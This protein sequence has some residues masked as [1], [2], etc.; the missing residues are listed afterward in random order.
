MANPNAATNP[1]QFYEDMSEAELGNL[2]PGPNIGRPSAPDIVEF[3]D[4]MLRYG[5]ERAAQLAEPV[6]PAPDAEAQ[7]LDAF[8]HDQVQTGQSREESQVLNTLQQDQQRT[9]ATREE[10]SS[11]QAL[12]QA[13]PT[14]DNVQRTADEPAQ[15]IERDGREALFGASEQ[16]EPEPGQEQAFERDGREELFR[17]DTPEQ[18]DQGPEQEQTQE[19]ERQMELDR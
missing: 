1:E 14:N 13:P 2:S 12:H 11:L 8:R 16:P 18:H 7:S 17:P 4:A 19:Q 9:G 5:Q 10:A 3:A 15:S 6:T